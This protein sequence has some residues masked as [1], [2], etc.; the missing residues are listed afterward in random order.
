MR[1]KGHANYKKD[2]ND[3]VCAGCS[4]A[5]QSLVLWCMQYSAHLSNIKLL[6]MQKGRVTV[7]ATGDEC[8]QAAFEVAAIGLEQIAQ[9]YPAYVEITK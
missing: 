2:G 1:M 4:T 7:D 6:D 8:F 3:I 9:K 5:G